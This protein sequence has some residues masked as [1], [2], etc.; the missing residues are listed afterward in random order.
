VK[1]AGGI[2]HQTTTDRGTETID[3]ARHQLNLMRQF[4]NVE[5]LDP[6]QAHRYTKSVHNQ[7]IEC[8]WSQLMKQYD[9]ELIR[10]LYEADEKGY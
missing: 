9:G 7:K 2:P 1:K 4:G 3:M 8:L 6:D 10:Q 5:D